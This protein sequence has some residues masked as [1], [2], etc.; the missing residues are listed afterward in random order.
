MA[1]VTGLP[2]EAPPQLLC[3]LRLH[4]PF[5]ALPSPASSLKSLLQFP[6]HQKRGLLWAP[7]QPCWPTHWGGYFHLNVLHPLQ[8]CPWTL[9]PSKVI[10]RLFT[11][12]Q[13]P[14][15]LLGGC[16]LTKGL[17]SNTSQTEPCY[18]TICCKSKST[19]LNLCKYLE[20]MKLCSKFYKDGHKS[21]VH[22]D[23]ICVLQC[24]KNVH[25]KHYKCTS[26]GP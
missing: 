17:A 11:H 7:W 21:G 18:V 25:I 23:Y 3:L 16:F 20:V 22:V 2:W 15:V 4:L 26:L 14:K 12:P 9:P 6:A 24:N 10:R 8:P 5:R 13:G 19:T 1:T